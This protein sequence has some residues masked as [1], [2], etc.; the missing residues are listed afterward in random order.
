LPLLGGDFAQSVQFRIASLASK[1]CLTGEL[2][3]TATVVAVRTTGALPAE[4]IVPV[5]RTVGDEGIEVEG[6]FLAR[7]IPIDPAPQLGHVKAIPVVLPP[8]LDI[9]E[10]SVE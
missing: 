4:E 8:G 5:H 2:V 6:F 9:L 1:T 10:L 7:R 3:E